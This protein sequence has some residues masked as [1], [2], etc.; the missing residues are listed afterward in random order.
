[1]SKRLIALLIGATVTLSLI[2][3]GSEEKNK[4]SENKGVSAT[5]RNEEHYKNLEGR[6]AKEYTL[7]E[8]KTEF[9]TL[10]KQVEDKT[11]GYGL[12]YSK[13]E[14][15]KEENGVT[16][17]TN[18]IYLDNEKPEADRLESLYFGMKVFGTD[19]ATGQITLKVSLNFDSEKAIKNNSFDFGDTS[20]AAYSEILTGSENR[21]YSDINNKILEIV[22]SEKGEG[23]IEGEIDGLYE[24]FTV[25]KDYIVYK[26]ETKIYEFKKGDDATK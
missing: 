5:S 9:T 7:D 2:G 22:K 12:E 23:V 1:M 18:N 17:S 8:L 11:K 13:D 16:I 10:V 26:L 14:T 19:L 15:V 6:W 24:E 20:L 25:H 3:C 21:D 4:A